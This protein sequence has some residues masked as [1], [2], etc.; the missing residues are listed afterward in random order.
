MTFH[1]V[2]M[3]EMEKSMLAVCPSLGALPY[4][5]QT[6]DSETGR[7]FA[8]PNKWIFSNVYFG[9]Y[10][11]DAKAG[12]VVTD[13]AFR[14]WPIANFT[15]PELFI[16]KQYLSRALQ[17][18]SGSA[19]GTPQLRGGGNL[20]NTPYATRFPKHDGFPMFDGKMYPQF[21]QQDFDLCTNPLWVTNWMQWQVVGQK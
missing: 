19:S 20:L 17:Q 14:Y 4:W 21:D 15:T 6:L 11:G 12:Y 18:Y 16:P 5:D 1:R 7:Y 13:G 3:L 8:D 9:S 2:L 10:T